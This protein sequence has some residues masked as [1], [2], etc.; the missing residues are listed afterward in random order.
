MK[1]AQRHL[2]KRTPY[3]IVMSRS[4][5]SAETQTCNLHKEGVRTRGKYIVEGRKSHCRGRTE[6]ISMSR[7]FF[8]SGATVMFPDKTSPSH[9]VNTSSR[10]RI[11]C[12]QCVARDL[13]PAL[14]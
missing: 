7:G 12:F 2:N 11:V 3:T 8:W 1:V 4:M 13:G 10:Y 6:I 9:I 5:H 14:I